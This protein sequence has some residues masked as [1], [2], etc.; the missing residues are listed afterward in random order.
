MQ[1]REYNFDGIPGPTHNYA[2]LSYGNLAS[3][4]HGGRVS[5]PRAAVLQGLAKMKRLHDLGAP[6]AVLPP[7][8]RPDLDILRRLGFGSDRPGDD[9]PA[10]LQRAAHEAPELLARASSASAMWTANAATVSPSA[11]TQDGRLHFTPANLS[12]SLHRSIEAPQTA[13]ILQRIFSDPAHFAHH[14]P[15]PSSLGDEGAANHTRLASEYGA[16]GLELFVYG[17]S[18]TPVS[19]A[20][21]DDDSGP[22]GETGEIGQADAAR[23]MRF[24]ARQLREASELSLIHI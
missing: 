10:L 14:P 17:A 5:H 20:G 21:Q 3:L 1:A 2:A 22:I 12:A 15:L 7:H 24:P 11:D 9:G 8:P 16:P 19:K 6:Q 4:Q 23:P 13:R 18:L